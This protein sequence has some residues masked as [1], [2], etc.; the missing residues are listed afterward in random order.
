MDRDKP[1]KLL[2]NIYPFAPELQLTSCA[3]P[4]PFYHL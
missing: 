1:Q 4:H 3:N 2:N